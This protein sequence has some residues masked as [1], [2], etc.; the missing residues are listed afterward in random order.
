MPRR[1][2]KK[3]QSQPVI[4]QPDSA[5]IDIGA[6]ELFVAVPPD[7]ADESVRSFGAFTE[8]LHALADW[9]AQC[10]IKSV[11]MESTGV[12]WIPVF[13]ILETRG[14]EVCLVN[15]RHVKNVPGRKSDVLDCQWLQ[16]LHTVGLLRGSFRPADQVCA[17]RTYLRHRDMLIKSAARHV[18][19]MQKALTQMNLHLHHVISDL[20]GVTGLAILDAIVGG[21]RDPRKLAALRDHRIKASEATIMKALVGDYRSEHL[22]TLRQALAIYRHYLAQVQD[23]DREVER[24]L[25]T[26][27]S[28]TSQPAPAAVGRQRKKPERHQPQ[29]DLRSHLHRILGVDLTALP[30]LSTINVHTLFSEVGADLSKFPSSKH[31]ASWLG[32]C[33]DNRISG[34]KVLSAHTRKVKS[35]AAFALRMAAYSAGNSHTHLGEYFRRMRARLGAPKAITATAH[36]LARIIFHLLTTGQPYDDSVFARNEATYQKRREDSLRKH[37]RDLGFALTPLPASEVVS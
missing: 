17:L 36:K 3:A 15:A 18:Q 25:G 16:Y 22:F 20:T 37:A 30:G 32:L 10:R 29:F 7:R 4:I 2:K 11:V 5:G 23:C 1:P 8:D 6:T 33:P 35:R 21:E 31:F 27:E 12:Y 26:F 9:L 19:H 14:F 24:Q 13:Q 34:G 28:K